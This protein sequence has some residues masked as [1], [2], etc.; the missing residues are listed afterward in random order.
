MGFQWHLPQ[1]G[2]F[3]TPECVMVRSKA[4]VGGMS[5]LLHRLFLDKLIPSSW[6]D[7]NPPVLLVIN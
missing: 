6:A 5:R 3:N 2:E 4:G 7:K 1:G